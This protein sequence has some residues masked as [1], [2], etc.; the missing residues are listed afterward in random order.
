[1]PNKKHLTTL[2]LILFAF[3]GYGTATDPS[4]AGRT[5][6]FER[7]SPVRRIPLEQGTTL[8]DFGKDAFGTLE[9]T[10]PAVRQERLLILLGEKL[11]QGRIDAHPG[12]SI[13]Y[14]ETVLEVYPGQDHY[15]L[16]LAPDKRNTQPGA[17]LLP[18]SFGVVLPFRYAEIRN[19]AQEI[20]AS[21]VRQK[22]LFTLFDDQ[23]SAF[24]S[25]D[26]ILN[27]VWDLCKYSIKATS[28][29][30][31]YIDGDRERIPYEADAYINQ[32][33][34]FC[35]DN[36]YAMAGHTLEWFMTHPTWPTE[37]ILHTA[38]IADELFQYSGDLDLIRRYYP[39]LKEK[40]LTSL[41]REDGLISTTT[42]KVD[43]WL[44]H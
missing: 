43:G 34:H 37:W 4:T 6:R 12:G 15:L 14:S 1:M 35:T 29:A 31:L 11:L 20:S 3:A 23:N 21:Q 16:H 5:V 19:A 39:L 36:R 33:G 10:Y 38:L 13:R 41:A 22:A 42:G 25:S 44:M 17:A 24:T 30:G 18:D 8:F 26:T 28:F 7:I 32:M 9:L 40:S 2:L 27:Q